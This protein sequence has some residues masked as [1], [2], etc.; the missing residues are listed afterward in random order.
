MK[1]ILNAD[2]ILENTTAA[3][4]IIEDLDCDELDKEILNGCMD[5]IWDSTMAIL[6]MND[7]ID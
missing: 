1:G 4:D 3:R 2:T 7:K 5:Q 6:K